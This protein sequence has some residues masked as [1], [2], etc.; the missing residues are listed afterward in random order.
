MKNLNLP[1]QL[2][3]DLPKELH[4]RLKLQAV[5]SEKTIQSIVIQALEDHLPMKLEVI[6]T[7]K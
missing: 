1:K 2:A 6:A 5:C 3:V 7:P 4:H